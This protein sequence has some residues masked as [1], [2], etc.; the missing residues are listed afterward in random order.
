[1]TT[2]ERQ[3]LRHFLAA[4]A[5]RTHKAVDRTRETYASFQVQPGVR[6]PEQLLHHMSGVLSYALSHFEPLDSWIDPLGDFAAEVDRFHDVLARIGVHL[7]QGSELDGTTAARLLQ[8]PFSD[9]MTH[10]GQLA[11][12]RRLSGDPIPPENFHVADISPDNVSA[13]QPAPVSPDATWLD[14]DGKPQG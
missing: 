6:T 3:L 10:A 13:R 4:L 9:A 7:D 5:Y 12:I 2:A 8:G 1:M 11:M 14:A